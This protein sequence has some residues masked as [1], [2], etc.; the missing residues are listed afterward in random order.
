MGKH[1]GKYSTAA[2]RWAGVGPYYAM[3]PTSF[4]DEVVCAHTRF[5]DSVLDPFA[6][7]GTAVFS[8][9][10]QGRHAIGIEINPLGYVYA[11]AKLQPS[12]YA[13]TI[14]KLCEL[15]E[16]SS[17]YK[18]QSTN[19]SAFFSLCFSPP[20]RQFLLAARA[21]L[22]WR[23]SRV[24]RTLMA[25]ILIALHGK[26]GQSL[27]NQMRQVT[28]MA[29]EYSIRWWGE[30]KLSPPD[31]EPISFLSKR[32][33]WRYKHGT[34]DTHNAIVYKDNSIKKLPSLARDVQEGRRPKVKLLVTSPPYH[35]ITN[36]YYDQWLRMWLLGNPDH[37]RSYSSRYGGKFSNPRVYRELLMQVFSKAKPV[38]DEE[39]TI[40]VRTDQRE[41]TL[42][43]TL[44]V[45][46]G[47]FPEKQLAQETHPLKPEQQA[48]PYGRG[49]A[50]KRPNC[51]VDLVLAPR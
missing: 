12:D 5:G 24:D 19:M 39:A 26:R 30:K 27:S 32:I 49:G 3:F 35:N 23:H 51:E 29:P 50:P 20:V 18:E 13:K 6:G 42:R 15:S 48:K 14:S 28:A 17:R 41:S 38:L 22:N 7:R 21:N 37:P 25:I 36:Y 33:A 34:P 8:A 43:P 47:L 4:A 11:N 9:A 2:A 10:T 16:I 46:T 31:I 40:Y 1:S 45:L 44:E